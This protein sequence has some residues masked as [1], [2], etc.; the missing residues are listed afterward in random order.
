MQ[1]C[2]RKEHHTKEKRMKTPAFFLFV[3]MASSCLHADELSDVKK[4]NESLKREVAG[5][6]RQAQK[7]TA[8]NTAPAADRK[9][10][11]RARYEEDRKTYS[12]E[13]LR[14]IEQLYQA[15]NRDL[16]S[17]EAKKHLSTLIEKYPKAN[18]TGCAVQYMG[19]M[20]TGAEKEKYLRM[21]I[22][23]FGD[24]YYGSGVQ[25]GAYARLYLA[26]YYKDLGKEKEAKALFDE[27]RKDFPDAVN[28]K[29]KPL[30]GMLPK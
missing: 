20:S 17:P 26:Y 4:E 9:A 27:I 30:V 12:G 15:A 25:V 18:R 23:D 5:L 11:I 29:G 14:E 7:G 8:Q 2:A 10:A 16:K 21:A 1:R 24:C 3:L 19:Q 22:K 13:Q 6:R 28:H